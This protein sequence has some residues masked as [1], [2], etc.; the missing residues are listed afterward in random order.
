MNKL[1]KV[2]IAEE[3][4]EALKIEEERNIRVC[5]SNLRTL[6]T[7]IA[8]FEAE[9]GHWPST[10]E[11]VLDAGYL[12]K[13]PIG[14]GGCTYD[15]DVASHRAVCSSIGSIPYLKWGRRGR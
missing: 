8:I 2:A 3:K 10:V 15:I 4:A 6:D 9:K 14:P 11:S 12:V 1:W 5:Q 7:S 13:V